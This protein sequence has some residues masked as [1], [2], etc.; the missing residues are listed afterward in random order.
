MPLD[1]F[2]ARLIGAEQVAR[3]AELMREALMRVKVQLQ[4]DL[5]PALVDV[6]EVAFERCTVKGT[7][8]WWLSAAKSC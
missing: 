6:R 3:K 8:T 5:R 1:R 7:T 2:A 4:I